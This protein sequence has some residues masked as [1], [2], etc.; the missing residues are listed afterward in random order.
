MKTI[1]LSVVAIV[2]SATVCLAEEKVPSWA[3]ADKDS[4]DWFTPTEPTKKQNVFCDKNSDLKDC[5]SP[6]RLANE[7]VTSGKFIT[8][9]DKNFIMTHKNTLYICSMWYMD[10]V[11]KVRCHINPDE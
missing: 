9:I 4:S 10:K 7:V 8:K 2:L 11:D 1:I 6:E 3:I 5:W